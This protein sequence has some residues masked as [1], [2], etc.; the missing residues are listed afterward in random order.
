MPTSALSSTFIYTP[1][2]EKVGN[3]LSMVLAPV[4]ERTVMGT[5][6]FKDTV[7]ATAP[8]S[9]LVGSCVAHSWQM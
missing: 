9:E 8:P 3:E 1:L 6:K 5:A 7:P 4:N 2:P